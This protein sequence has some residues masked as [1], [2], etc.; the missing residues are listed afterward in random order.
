MNNFIEKKFAP[1]IFKKN[2]EKT[3]IICPKDDN[4]FLL[5]QNFD[6]RCLKVNNKMIILKIKF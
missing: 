5:L 3:I 2:L 1:V 6:Q 4:S